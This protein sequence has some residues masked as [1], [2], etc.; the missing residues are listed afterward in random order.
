MTNNIIKISIADGRRIGADV[1]VFPWTHPQMMQGVEFQ[2]DPGSAVNG[3]GLMLRC[4]SLGIHIGGGTARA[5]LGEAHPAVLLSREE[6]DLV[7][8]A[9]RRVNRN[10]DRRRMIDRDRKR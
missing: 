7:L 3:G 2:I 4:S 1:E 9:Q 5:I 8:R 6:T 10:I